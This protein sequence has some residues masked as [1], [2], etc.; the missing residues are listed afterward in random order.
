[1]AGPSVFGPDVYAS[2]RDVNGRVVA[3]LRGVTDRRGLQ[4]TDVRS[5]AVP[6]YA[7]HELMTTDEDAG[8]GSDVDRV[9][10]LGFFEVETGGVILVGDD[11]Y[12]GNTLLGTVAGFDET[13]MPNH[14]NICLRVNNL[15]DGETMGLSVEDAVRFVRRRL[16]EV[17]GSSSE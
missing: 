11:A 12:S 2:R 10:L 5:R 8:L 16:D 14:Q 17:S 15:V 1:V 4:L 13:H 7:I 6:K 3:V 9:A